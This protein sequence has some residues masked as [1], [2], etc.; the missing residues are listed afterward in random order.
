[1]NYWKKICRLRSFRILLLLVF[2]S[3]QVIGTLCVDDLRIL[4]I[5]GTIAT[6]VFAAV[7]V[8]MGFEIEC[9]SFNG[10]TC[11]Q[12]GGKLEYF[13]TNSQGGRGYMCDSCDYTTW[14]SYTY[15]D[16][17]YWRDCHAKRNENHN[18]RW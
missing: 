14:V 3:F 6:S 16:R 9:M 18:C 7:F 12:C 17:D 1:M 15:V 10:G 5:F 2:I 8:Y 4:L 13:D 11:I